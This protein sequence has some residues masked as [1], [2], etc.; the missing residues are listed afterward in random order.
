MSVD[1]ARKADAETEATNW[2]W[3]KQPEEVFDL[4]IPGPAGQLTLRV[5]R[6]QS[7][8]PLPVLVYFFGG[9]WVVGSLDTSDAICRTLSAKVPCVIVSVGYRLAPEHPFPAAIDDCYAAVKWVAEHAAELGA[10]GGRIGLAGDSS[11]GNLAAALALMARDD[12]GPSIS[13]QVLVYPPTR[14]SGADTKSMRDNTDPMFFNA[15]SS[16]WFWDHYL[17]DPADGESP[18]ASPLNA[19]DHSGLPA[20]L[21]MTAEYC[22]LYDEGE[23]YADALK[24]AGV[25]VEYHPYT[26]LPHGFLALA[27]V[28]DTARDAFD[29]IADFL[30]RRLG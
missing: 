5:Y 27:S 18:Y 29:V 6:P 4:D 14:S 11:G 1:Q 30:R 20:A 22:P 2:D 21:M 9:G 17:A 16:A 26:S 8:G 25:P 12:D 3:I 13:A 24:R 23:A 10:D 7:D 28:L 19:A 15:Y